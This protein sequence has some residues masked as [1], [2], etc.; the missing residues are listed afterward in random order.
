MS[1]AYAGV[2]LFADSSMTIWWTSS[3]TGPAQLVFDERC[4]RLLGL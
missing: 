4:E 1:A 2:E 3:L